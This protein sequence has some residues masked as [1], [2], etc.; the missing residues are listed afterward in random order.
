[1]QHDAQAPSLLGSDLV[2]LGIGLST[3]IL[4]AIVLAAIN[5]RFHVALWAFVA[6]FVVPL[7]AIGC[8][9]VS[10]FGYE[11]ASRV[12]GRRP[13]RVATAGIVSGGI[14]TYTLI[15]V[16]EYMLADVNGL[17]V[18][19]LMS[20]ASFIDVSIRGTTFSF[21]GHRVGGSLETM[22]FG[23]AFL[24]LLGF[25]FGSL[26]VYG[27]PGLSRV[28]CD[29]CARYS[30][31]MEPVAGYAAVP[32][33]QPMFTYARALLAEGNADSAR[34]I[35]AHV[36]ER[37][38]TDRL[39]LESWRCAACRRDYHRLRLEKYQSG[40]GYVPLGKIG[41]GPKWVPIPEFVYAAHGPSSVSSRV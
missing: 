34:E 38:A 17:R 16:F 9:I 40:P 12:I 35:I 23:V 41:G 13:G 39:M 32:Q 27:M 33:L 37:D 28:A 24:N 7:G 36:G 22:G 21:N 6:Y 3:N 19:S 10:G 1:M 30:R 15:Y 5:I 26:A 11:L 8:G 4:L 18:S 31:T 25:W 14:L 20:F 2:F 29:R